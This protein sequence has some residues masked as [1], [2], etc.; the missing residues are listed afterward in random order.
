M[1]GP[2]VVGVDGSQS[3]LSAVD[4]AAHEAQIRGV[5]L[6]VVHAFIW[7][8]MHVSL[9]PSAMGPADG[10]LRNLAVR[11]LDEAVA[12]ARAAAP[13]VEVT[14]DLITGEPLAVLEA[15]SRTASLVVVGSRGMGGF[16]GLL[17]GST[18]VHLSTY[19][20]CPVLV[21]RGAPDPTGPVL[22]AADGSPQAEAAVGFAFAEASLRGADL[23]ALHAWGSWSERGDDD[24]GHPD[25]LVDDLD[26][27]QST[28]ERVL[29]EALSGWQAKYPD[30]T[31][32]RQLVR[33]RP[34]QALIEASGAAQ[35]LVVGA[36]GRGGFAGLLLGSV[37]QAA[38][39]HANCP[40]AVVRAGQ[41]D[42]D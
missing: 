11:T 7:P 26:R 39:H 16:I 5:G 24:P 38:L 40:V 31:V 1:N 21:V 34:R 36:R 17:V 15:Q 42:Q 9:G 33:N 6:H 22:L 29:A 27:L 13:D 20:R 8:K 3:S 4:T 41:L 12:R 18:A 28:E 25:N 2:V 10:G 32:R 23:V 19:G 37:S 35:L 30:V 14:Q